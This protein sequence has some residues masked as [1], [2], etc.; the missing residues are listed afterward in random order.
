VAWI[1]KLLLCTTLPDVL[2]IQESHLTPKYQPSIQWCSKVKCRPGPTI[3][4]APFPPLK[5]AYKNFKWKFM[6]RV[7]SKIGLIKH[8]QNRNQTLT[9]WNMSCFWLSI[10]ILAFSAW[11]HLSHHQFFYFLLSLH[12]HM[13]TQH[14]SSNFPP[15]WFLNLRWAHRMTF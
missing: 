2:C 1:K 13:R 5:F 7:N 14:V 9:N 4:V 12:R 11:R 3:K 8:L 10:M 15:C 6:F